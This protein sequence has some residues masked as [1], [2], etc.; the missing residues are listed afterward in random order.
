VT[1][2]NYILDLDIG[3]WTVPDL[4]QGKLLYKLSRLRRIGHYNNMMSDLITATSLTTKM[5]V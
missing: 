1:W 2:L 5:Y 4:K 3:I